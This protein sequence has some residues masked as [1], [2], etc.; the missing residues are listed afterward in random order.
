VAT[1][2]RLAAIMFTDMVGFTTAAQRNEAA[3]LELLEEME[4]IVR[5]IVR[6]HGGREVKSTG[7]GSLIELSSALQAVECAI[8]IQ[9]RLHERNAAPG[10]PPIYLRIAIHVGDVEGRGADIFGDA[11]NIAARVLP[12]AEPDGVALTEQVAHHLKNKLDVPVESLGARGLKGVDEPV[13]VFRVVLPWSGPALASRDRLLPRLAVL[14]LRNISPD[15]DDAYFADGLTEE[16]ISVL[17]QVQEL[18]VIGRSSAA[19][20][21]AGDRP[22]PEIGRELGASAVLEGSV[23]KAGERLRISLQLVDVATQEGLWTQTF[24]RRLD[25]VFAVQTEV[26]ER[27]AAALRLRMVGAGGAVPNKLPTTNLAAYGLYL[28]GLHRIHSSR[29]EDVGATVDLF[30]RAIAEDPAF[31][32]AYSRLANCLL[33]SIGELSPAREVIPQVRPLVEKALSLDPSSPEAHTA[34]GNLAMQADLD[35]TVAEAEFRYALARNPSDADPRRWYGML[36][37]ALQRYREAEEQ[38]RVMVELDPLVPGGPIFLVSIQRLAGDVEAAFRTTRTL[39][40]PLETPASVHVNL[41]YTYFYA[42]RLEEARRELDEELAASGGQ[43]SL[44]HDILLARLGDP[45][46]ARRRLEAEAQLAEKAYVPPIMLATLAAAVGDTER[47]LGY[48]ERDWSDGDRGLWYMYQGT[49]FDPIR[50]DPRF[51]RLLERY[52]LPT[53]APFYRMG[54]RG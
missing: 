18:R 44:D 49:A 26:G 16:L 33:G 38:A 20:F 22:L 47:A 40:P 41:A 34:N 10:V 9:H 3:A 43:R 4:A 30:R 19:R 7:D 11:V 17:G 46:A 25:D 14:P 42:A 52:R 2:R 13:P 35:W 36:L 21:G 8:A 27:T 6:A 15:P 37:R 23:R 54:R 12:V 51:L 50:S 28:Q 5:P 24:D 1:G 48:L 45:T 29:P 31:S 53:S 39:L 32:G